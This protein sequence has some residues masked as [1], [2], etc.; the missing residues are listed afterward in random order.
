M[1]IGFADALLTFKPP[2]VQKAMSLYREVVDIEP[3]HITANERIEEFQAQEPSTPGLP[4]DLM[5]KPPT[6][7]FIRKNYGQQVC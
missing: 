3:Q 2:Y 6:Q 7:K 5:V 1:L 4:G